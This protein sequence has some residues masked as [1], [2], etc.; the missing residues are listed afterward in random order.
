MVQF[1]V[2]EPAGAGRD[3]RGASGEPGRD[4]G[5]FGDRSDRPLRGGVVQRSGIAYLHAGEE[6]YPPSRAQAE[7]DLLAQD[8]GGDIHVTLPVIVHVA[9]ADDYEARVS[10]IADLALRRLRHAI[11]SQRL[12]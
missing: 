1:G 7:I 12:V 4:A 5:R 3:R 11:E 8:L 6:V 10:E 9:A 2:A